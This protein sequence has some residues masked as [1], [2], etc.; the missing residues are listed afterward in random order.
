DL[1]ARFHLGPRRLVGGAS[2]TEPQRQRRAV[3]LREGRSAQA[4]E[5]YQEGRSVTQPAQLVQVD[6]QREVSGESSAGLVQI[7]VEGGV[8]R[9]LRIVEEE[10]RAAGGI[11]FPP[12]RELVA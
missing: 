8:V 11:A 4:A 6:H 10:V 2:E 3:Y 1:E 5:T 9:P 7:H 12:P